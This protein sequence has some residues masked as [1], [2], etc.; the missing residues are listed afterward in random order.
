MQE[1]NYTVFLWIMRKHSIKL[2]DHYYGKSFY[3]KMLEMYARYKHDFEIE[4]YLDFITEKNYKCALTQFRSSSHDLAIERGR[5]ENLNRNERI[6]KFCN[7][8]SVEL[9]ITFY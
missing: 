1:K 4:N 5:Y 9:N 2:I 8:N 7:S 6:C 3:L